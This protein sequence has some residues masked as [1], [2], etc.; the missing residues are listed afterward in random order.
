MQSTA[1]RYSFN[2]LA[3]AADFTCD[4]T[5]TTDPG[6]PMDKT[7]CLIP[8]P[9]IKLRCVSKLQAGVGDWPVLGTRV[10][11]HGGTT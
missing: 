7:P 8:D 11:Y 6:V 1:A 5:K 2:N 4:P 3:N 9:A 10:R